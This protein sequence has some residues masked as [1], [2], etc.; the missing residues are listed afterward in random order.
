MQAVGRFQVVYD[1]A[2]MKSPRLRTVF[3]SGLLSACDPYGQGLRPRDPK[4]VQLEKTKPPNTC[5]ELETLV[6]DA[7]NGPGA[8]SKAKTRLREK[9]ANIGANYVLW[10]TFEISED[11]PVTTIRGIA[12]LCPAEGLPAES[13]PPAPVTP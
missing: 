1:Y 11:P 8:V 5:Q 7:L 4:D 3:L 6:A 2:R 10:D 12:Y 9:A 13:T